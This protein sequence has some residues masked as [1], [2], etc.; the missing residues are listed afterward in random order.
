[1]KSKTM[2]RLRKSSSRYNAHIEHVANDETDKVISYINNQ[3][4]GWKADVCKLQKHHIEYGS[5]C[6][7]QNSDAISLA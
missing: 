6:E 2:E 3:N 5:H 7:N 4:F 1:M